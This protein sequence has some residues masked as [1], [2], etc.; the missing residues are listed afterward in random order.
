METPSFWS[1][2][3]SIGEDISTVPGPDRNDLLDHMI[4]TRVN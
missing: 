2:L 3:I 4:K 1:D